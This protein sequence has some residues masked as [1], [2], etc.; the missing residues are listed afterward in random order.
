MD[1]YYLLEMKLYIIPSGFDIYWRYYADV[2]ITNGTL[3]LDLLHTSHVTR[4][5]LR[6]MSPSPMFVYIQEHASLQSTYLIMLVPFL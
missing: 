3:I 2:N 4:Q 6:Q 1:A 5:L